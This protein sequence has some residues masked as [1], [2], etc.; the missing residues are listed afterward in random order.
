[1]K[2]RDTSSSIPG[3][4][5]RQGQRESAA[6]GQKKNAS[7]RPPSCAAA[8]SS[9]SWMAKSVRVSKSPRAMP[10]WLVATTMR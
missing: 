9:A 6:W 10:D 5:L 1:L 2:R 7:M 4:G 3:C 8:R